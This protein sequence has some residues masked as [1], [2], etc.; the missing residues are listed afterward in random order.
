V[1]V[2]DYTAFFS[3]LILFLVGIVFA[4]WVSYT[5]SGNLKRN[6]VQEAEYFRQCQYCSHVY[7]DYLKRSP[8]R[9]PRCLSYH[10]Q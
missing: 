7:L 5:L 10:D 1:F 8:C 6:R 4:A 2:W 9:C 3:A